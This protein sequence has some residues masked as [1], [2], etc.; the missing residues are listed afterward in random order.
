[1]PAKA[2]IQGFEAA[3]QDSRLRG[4][5]KATRTPHPAG[6]A[7]HLLPRGEGN[8]PAS[9]VRAGGFGLAG[10]AP[11]RSSRQESF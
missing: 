1:M 5:D 7:G 2:G 8:H 9:S 3:A 6:F 11:L 10:V 4:N